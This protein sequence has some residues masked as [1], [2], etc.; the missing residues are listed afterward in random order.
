MKGGELGALLLDRN[1]ALGDDVGASLIDGDGGLGDRPGDHR[2]R[3]ALTGRRVLG[4]AGAEGK[5]QGS[6]EQ[7][8]R[9]ERT[10]RRDRQSSTHGDSPRPRHK[11]RRV[12]ARNRGL[13][14][15]F[16]VLR[17]RGVSSDRTSA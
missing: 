1:L 2:G 11:A 9:A 12:P 16:W 13:D 6:G 8:E 4:D 7:R 17:R 5:R 3:I 15:V 10:Q 14:A